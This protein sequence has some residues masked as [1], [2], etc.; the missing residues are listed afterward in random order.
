YPGQQYPEPQGYRTGQGSPADPVAPGYGGQQGGQQGGGSWWGGQQPGSQAPMPGQ[1]MPAAEQWYGPGAVRSGQRKRPKWIAPVAAAA[2]IVVIVVA[3]VVALSP[4]SSKNGAASGSSASQS[5]SAPS[6]PSA[7]PV[8][9]TGELTLAQFQA[10]DCL[11]GANLQLNKPTPW[12]KLSQAV[13]CT[14]GHTAEVFY[15]NVNHWSKNTPFPGAD[16]VRKN[17]TAACNSA[18]ASYVGIAYSKSVYTWTDIVPDASS[19]PNG[20]RALRCVA[21]YSTNANPAGETLHSS[22]KGAAN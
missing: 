14:E 11:T 22:I 18:F 7:A 21:Y 12:P 20:D 5:Q 1:G 19:W 13:P 2:A 8:R 3:L 4:G 16:G 6:S 9:T 10:G 15:A 17:A